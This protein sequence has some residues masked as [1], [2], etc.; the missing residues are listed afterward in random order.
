[1]IRISRRQARVV[2]RV[3]PHISRRRVH[4]RRLIWP[5]SDTQEWS[6]MKA[7]QDE[8]LGEPIPAEW[9]RDDERTFETP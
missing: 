4:E 8:V 3:W 9:M 2:R 6:R 1:M 7:R 5:N